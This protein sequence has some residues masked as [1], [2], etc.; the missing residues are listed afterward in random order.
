VGTGAAG[1]YCRGRREHERC[2]Q[3]CQDYSQR[4]VPPHG[5]PH[6][7]GTPGALGVAGAKPLFSFFTNCGV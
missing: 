1:A 5:E 4:G 6:E 7:E 2:C 3:C